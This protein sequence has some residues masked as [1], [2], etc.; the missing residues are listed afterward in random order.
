MK[1]LRRLFFLL[2]ALVLVGSVIVFTLPAQLAYRWAAGELGPLRLQGIDGTVW[3]GRAAGVTAFAQPLGS[4]EWQVAKWP[5]LSRRVEAQLNLSGGQVQAKGLV[6]REAN[7]ELHASG[8]DFT[9]PASMAEPAIDIPALKLHGEI[10][11]R[12]EDAIVLGGWV[13]G[14]HGTARWQHAGVSGQAEARFGDL[15]VDFASQPDGSIRGTVKDDQSSNL[16]VDGQFVVQA[17]Q[18]DA[19]ATL[20]ARNEDM[21]MRETL[22]FIGQ[23]QPD[24]TSLLKIHGQLYKLF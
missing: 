24:G 14:A 8:V 1:I 18:F 15:L 17:A 12:L 2:I 3:D 22:Q 9:M 4:L 5:L 10:V 21:T 16:Q 11:G 13:S 6:R 23:P 19:Q 20:S 7:G